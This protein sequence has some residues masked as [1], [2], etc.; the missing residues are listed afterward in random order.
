MNRIEPRP[1]PKAFITVFSS[2]FF[3]PSSSCSSRACTLRQS[4]H[5]TCTNPF[6]GPFDGFRGIDLPN[7]VSLRVCSRCICSSNTSSETDSREMGLLMVSEAFG[8]GSASVL[9]ICRDEIRLIQASLMNP[10]TSLIFSSA[11]ACVCV[12]TYVCV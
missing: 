8:T 7:A 10:C 6:A 2:F 5:Y 9:F 1:A 11:P 4:P 12:C 3:L